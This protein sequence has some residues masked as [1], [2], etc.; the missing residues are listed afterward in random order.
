MH[1]MNLMQFYQRFPD[2]LSAMMAVKQIREKHG[3][4][5][6]KCSHDHLTG[7]ERSNRF[8][9]SSAGPD[10]ACAVEP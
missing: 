7:S 6:R 3:V 8:N 1:T 9:A 2:E 5:C 4:I 10:S